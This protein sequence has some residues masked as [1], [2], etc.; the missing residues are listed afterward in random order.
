MAT[1]D[2][3]TV[4]ASPARERLREA[5]KQLNWFLWST[6]LAY[7]F[8]LTSGDERLQDKECLVSES[9]ADVQAQAW[10]PNHKGSRKYNAKVAT[11][12][13]QIGTN[14]TFAFLLPLLLGMPSSSIT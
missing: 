13:E 5:Q 7:G 4:I 3:V 9:L 2:S 1:D 14:I 6:E 8:T 12:R 10:Y 11:F